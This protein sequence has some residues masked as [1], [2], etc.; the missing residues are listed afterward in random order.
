[1]PIRFVSSAF[2]RFLN[3]EIAGGVLLFSA[4][5]LAIAFAN[6]PGLAEWR[7]HFLHLPVGIHAGELAGELSL[8]HWIND[9]LMAVFFLLVGMEIKRELICGE[10]SS[11][12]RAMLPAIVAVAGMAGPAAVYVYFNIGDATAMRGWAIPTATDIAFSLGVLSLLGSRVPIALK[13]FLT[14]IAV[15]DDL[16]AIAIIAVFYTD[17]LAAAPLVFSLLIIF[18]LFLLNRKGV[19]ARAP[20]I[21]LGAIL[22]ICVLKS[23]VHATLAGVAL[24]FTIP[25]RVKTSEMNPLSPLE[26]FEHDL[27]PFVTFF[28]LPIFAFANAGVNFSGLS[29]SA[30]TLPIP[31]GIA[32][33][34]VFGKMIGIFGATYLCVKLR[35]APLPGDCG[36]IPI[37]AVALLCGI[38]FTVSLFIGNLAFGDVG[39]ETINLVKLGVLG[40]STCAGIMGYIALRIGLPPSSRES[41]A[42]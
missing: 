8:S 14:A 32:L 25:L 28:I 6:T 34:L 10:L 19:L 5:L 31:S 27:H 16:G 38:G 15:M 37:F 35:L 12:S 3:L 17:D 1:M 39:E 41:Q 36:W 7:E 21:L 24:A 30:M 11:R 23:G 9:G 42:N 20:Y 33:G 4:A 40:G 26:S 18:A 13:V 29:F 22:W 2:I